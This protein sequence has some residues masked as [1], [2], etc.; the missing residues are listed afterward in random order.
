MKKDYQ[1][2]ESRLDFAC[3]TL[4]SYLGGK[5]DNYVMLL[6]RSTSAT[7]ATSLNLELKPFELAEAMEKLW[8]NFKQVTLVSATLV[9]TSIAET[10]KTFNANDWNTANFPSPFQYSKQMRVFLP[11]KN[12]EITSA[13]AIAENIK[14]IA[15]ITDGQGPR[16]VHELPDHRRGDTADDGLVQGQ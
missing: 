12:S 9:G 6:N 1:E 14:Q 2:M 11:P 15:Q 3:T 7:G 13:P 8:N 4:D 10:K 16:A 5:V